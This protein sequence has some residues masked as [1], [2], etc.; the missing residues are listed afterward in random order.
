[1]SAVE[2]YT[3]T[4]CPY[5]VRA[6]ALLEHKNVEFTEINVDQAPQL[7]AQMRERANGGNSVPQI[8]IN[9][10]HIGGCDDMMLLERQGKLDALLK[11]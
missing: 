7:R 10:Q 8:F 4:Y 3:T 1:M 9:E 6:K 5:C 11:H 2:V